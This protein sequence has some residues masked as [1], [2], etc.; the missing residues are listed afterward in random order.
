[1]FILAHVRRIR[2]RDAILALILGAALMAVVV[3]S[4]RLVPLMGAPPML[5]MVSK[6][7]WPWYV[8]TGT[9]LTVTIGIG[10]SFV[11]ARARAEASK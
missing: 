1:V 9:A 11:P 8:P 4:A 7:A 2:E 5:V 3:F 10:A 6:L